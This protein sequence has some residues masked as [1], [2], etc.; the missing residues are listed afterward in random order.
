[1]EVHVV[2]GNHIKKNHALQVT[3]HTKVIWLSQSQRQEFQWMDF[4]V[5][6]ETGINVLDLCML[7]KENVTTHHLAMEVNHVLGLQWRKD[8]ANQE[9][10]LA[11]SLTMI[12]FIQPVG[13]AFVERRKIQTRVYV[14][15][16]G[17]PGVA[18]EWRILKQEDV[19]THHLVLVPNTV[20]GSQLRQFHVFQEQHPGF[21]TKVY[22]RL[23][24]TVIMMV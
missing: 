22:A 10:H 23:M 16:N 13:M 9:Q 2:Q 21:W 12:I 1:M 17:D 14:A 15:V 8:H 20:V 5:N 4:G 24:V 6:G 11:K 19:T 3:M 7:E 18:V